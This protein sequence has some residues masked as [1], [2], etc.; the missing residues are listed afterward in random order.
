MQISVFHCT[1]TLQ[2]VVVPLSL[3]IASSR[4][5]FSYPRHIRELNPKLVRSSTIEKCFCNVCTYY[6]LWSTSI[7]LSFYFLCQ[8]ECGGFI[9]VRKKLSALCWRRHLDAQ[10]AVGTLQNTHT[11]LGPFKQSYVL[12][13]LKK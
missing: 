6:I 2:Q 7:N 12:V 8:V 4:M 11:S 9:N 1:T 10:C 5:T 3:S 13:L